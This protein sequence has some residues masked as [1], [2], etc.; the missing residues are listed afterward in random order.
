MD[1]ITKPE[2]RSGHSRVVNYNRVYNVPVP[3]AVG[4]PTPVVY[5]VP[6]VK[7]EYVP[8]EEKQECDSCC[9]GNKG[10]VAK[11]V[12]H[13]EVNWV[14]GSGSKRR[15]VSNRDPNDSSEEADANAPRNWNDVVER[16]NALNGEN[17]ALISK[18]I[19]GETFE[20][21]A[22]ARRNFEMI[23]KVKGIT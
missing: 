11:I 16:F 5:T 22:E 12:N 10:G 9:C 4:V 15:S 8:V 17:G 6:Y 1:T 23:S 3:R 19:L 14:S 20:Q 7:Y 13:T 2:V 21:E 18:G